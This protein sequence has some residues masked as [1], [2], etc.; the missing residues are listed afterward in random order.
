MKSYLRK[1]LVIIP[2]LVLTASSLTVTLPQSAQAITGSDFIAGRLT[3]DPIFFDNTRMDVHGIQAFLN[4]KVPVCD[5]WGTQPYNGT[6]RRAYSESRGVSFPLTC[7]KDFQ[8]AV[9]HTAGD[10]YCPGTIGSAQKNAAQIIKEVSDACSIN[11]MALL[12][13]LQKEQSL[14]TDDW[15]WPVQYQKATGFGCPDTAPCDSQYFGFFNQ[16]YRAARQFHRYSQQPHLYNYRAGQANY[17]QYNP[18]AGC[19]GSQVYIHNQATAGLYNYTPYQP[20]QALLNNIYGSGD[21]CSAF[22]NLNFW[23]I[24]NDW[25]GSP[26]TSY[27]FYGSPGQIVTDVTFRKYNHGIDQGNL[28][29]YSGSSTNCIESHTWNIGVTSWNANVASN[30]PIVL[31]ANAQVHYADLNGDGQDEPVLVGLNPTGSG[32]IEFHVWNRDM[33]KWTSHIASTAAADSI[34]NGKVVFGDINGDRRDEPIVILFNNTG[35]G[36]VEFHV[37]DNDLRNWREHKATHMPSVNM[38]DATVAFGDVDGNG[39]DEP[40]LILYRNTGSQRVEFHTFVPEWNAWRFNTA[41]NLPAMDPANGFITFADVD[42]NGADE[43][44]LVSLKNT[45]SGRIEFHTWNVGVTSWRYHTAS[46]QQ[47]F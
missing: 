3:D 30:H 24:Y 11:P 2:L 9:P 19:G 32:K 8:Q 21:G 45:G 41:S 31:P 47:T 22:G 14:V 36:K 38:S 5:N 25:F 28:L 18:N 43:A 34:T 23:K 39:V 15:P 29:I 40:V 37:W 12:V 13:L 44:V 4:S 46:N 27:C 17:I 26:V 33:N 35:S 42:G 6:T 16:V 10:Q 1:L 20:N 7:L